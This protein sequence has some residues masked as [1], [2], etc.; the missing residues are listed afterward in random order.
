VSPQKQNESGREVYTLLILKF[1]AIG[2]DVD[3]TDLE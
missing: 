3:L 1:L 2:T